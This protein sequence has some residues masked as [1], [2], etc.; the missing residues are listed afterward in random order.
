MFEQITGMTVAAMDATFAPLMAFGPMVSLFA[1]S[2]AITVSIT[3][4]GRLLT[5]NKA[6]KELKSKMQ[7]LR[8]QMTAAQKAGDKDAVNRLLEQTMR[9]NNEFMKHSYKSLFVS[10]VVISIFLPWLR[11]S[12]EG[13]AIASLPFALP[14]V[15]TS[16]TWVVWYILVSFTIGWVVRKMFGFE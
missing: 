12:Y 1:V 8:E 9:M 5:N 14:F 4:L 2:A 10:L 16:L 13:M 11:H 15:G 3:L 7:E 6:V